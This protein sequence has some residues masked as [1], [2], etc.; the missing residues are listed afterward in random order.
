MLESSKEIRSC[1]AHAAACARWA[2]AAAAEMREGY[3][4]LEKSWMSL[5]RSYQSAQRLLTYNE[6]KKKRGIWRTTVN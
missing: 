2:E 5:A 6:R 3:L 4:R 1:L